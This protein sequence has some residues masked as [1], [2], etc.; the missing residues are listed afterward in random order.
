MIR[1]SHRRCSVTK[2]VPRNFKNARATP[3]PK[4][5]H[6]I[7]REVL[8]R[9]FSCEF[10]EIS[11]NTFFTEHLCESASWWLLILSNLEFKFKEQFYRVYRGQWDILSI[12]LKKNVFAF[13]LLIFTEGQICGIRNTKRFDWKISVQLSI[14]FFKSE[15][16]IFRQYW[17]Q[18]F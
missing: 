12:V 18:T 8:A 1:S 4:A 5:W 3:Q 2:R 11:K 16:Q 17:R 9:V 14:T 7:K 10:S 6:F 15:N 13:L